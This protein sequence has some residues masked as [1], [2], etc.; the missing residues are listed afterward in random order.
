[1]QLF[2]MKRF[3]KLSLFIS[4]EVLSSAKSLMAKVSEWPLDHR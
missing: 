1:M 4:Q 2:V 3:I